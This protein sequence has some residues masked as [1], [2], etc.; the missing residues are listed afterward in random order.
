MSYRRR[1]IGQAG[2]GDDPC[3]IS[4]YASLFVLGVPANTDC[5]TYMSCQNA[6][7]VSNAVASGVNAA[8]AGAAQ[9]FQASSQSASNVSA[10]LILGGIGIVAA[11]AFA[12]FGK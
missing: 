5:L 4:D 2:C 1:G 8:A 3:G 10:W 9:G 12:K 7:T 6:V 11:L